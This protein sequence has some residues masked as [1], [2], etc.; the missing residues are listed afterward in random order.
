MEV[1]GCAELGSQS[2]DEVNVCYRVG[3]AV[4][5]AAYNFSPMRRHREVRIKIPKYVCFVEFTHVAWLHA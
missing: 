3:I 4:G 2:E 1:D 5:R